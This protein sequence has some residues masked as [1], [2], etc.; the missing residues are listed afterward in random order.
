VGFF[1]IINIFP[2]LKK[3]YI[4]LKENTALPILLVIFLLIPIGF[5]FLVT[6]LIDLSLTPDYLNLWIAALSILIG[7]LIN[8]LILLLSS[9]KKNRK[10]YN[11]LIIQTSYNAAYEIVIGIFILIYALFL[12]LLYENMTYL[13]L[14]ITSF[15]FHFILFHY[16]ITLLMVIRR[17]YYIIVV[18]SKE[19]DIDL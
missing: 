9:D 18:K 13:A 3:H 14:K 19:W 17:L 15:V 7:F 5:A 11:K 16:L 8:A 10:R 1:S 12:V 4:I 6:Y 2:A